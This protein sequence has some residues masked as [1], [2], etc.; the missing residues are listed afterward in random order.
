[1]E[2]SFL[3]THREE[4]SSRCYRTFMKETDCKISLYMPTDMIEDL[5]YK[6]DAMSVH[7]NNLVL[8][9][10]ARRLDQ[11]QAQ[12]E[13]QRAWQTRED[14]GIPHEVCSQTSYALS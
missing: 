2:L 14:L 3:N 7:F 9:I 5:Q 8:Q 13:E 12:I 11:S 1:M 4:L 6:A 10:L